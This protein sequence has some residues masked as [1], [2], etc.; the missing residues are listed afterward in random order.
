MSSTLITNSNDISSLELKIVADL[1]VGK[2]YMDIT[3]SV[4]IGSGEDLVLGANF[5]IVNPK[6]VIVKPFGSNYEIAPGLSGGMETVVSY[7]VPTIAGNYQY[8]SYTISVELY[9]A[10]GNKY[11]NTKP[12]TICEPD[13]LNKTKKYGTLSANLKGVCKDG[14]LWVIVDGVPNYK[15]A[16]VDSQVNLFTLYY[17]TVSGIDPLED[18]S[19]SNFTVQLYEGE[20]ILEGTVCALYNL[21][22]NV[23]VKINYVVNKKHIVKCSIDFCC[24]QQQFAALKERMNTDCTD[25]EK[26]DLA[27]T[28]V[29][30]LFYLETAKLAADCGQDPSEYISSLEKLLGCSCTCNCAEGTPVID[31]TPSIDVAIEGCGFTKTVVGLTHT[32]TL[33]NYTY[34]V[35]ITDNGGAL[36]INEATTDGCTKTQT[37]QFNISVVYSQIKG[38]ALSNQTEANF[39]ASV[40]RKALVGLDASCLGLTPSQYAQLTFAQLFQKVFDKF[41]ACCGCAAE[42]SNLTTTQIGNDIMFNWDETNVYSV[43]IYINNIFV[44]NILAGIGQYRYIAPKD[45]EQLNSYRLVPKCENGSS[46]TPLSGTTEFTG[47]VYIVPPSVYTPHLVGTC[48]YDLTT[49]VLPLPLGI[50]AEWHTANNTLATSLVSDPTNAIQSAYFVFAKDSNNFYSEGVQVTLV[51]DVTGSCSAPQNLSVVPAF[52]GNL[53]KFQSAAYPPPLNSY[54]VKRRLKSDT[55]I[56]AN[57]TVIGTPVWNASAS[58]WVISDPSAVSNVLYVYRAFSNCGGTAPYIDYEFAS[59]VCPSLTIVPKVSYVNYS[60]TEGG[61]EIDKYEVSIYESDGVTLVHTNT[62]IA[63]FSTPVTG[64]FAYLDSSTN[65]K[66]GVKVYI[67]TYVKDCGQE[68]SATLS[69]TS[70]LTLDYIAGTWSA[71][72]SHELPLSIVIGNNGQFVIGSQVAG[73]GDTFETD[74]LGEYEIAAGSLSMSDETDGL[75]YLSTYYHIQDGLYIAGH[76]EINSGDSIMYGETELTVIINHLECGY[77]P[78]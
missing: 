65:Y 40:V 3:P 24:V 12:V 45:Y 32:Y 5:Q 37:I 38:I 36:T 15:G 70:T 52:G 28:I 10:A 21:T 7:N 43:D 46:G 31:A 34:I 48:P 35:A 54:T 73:C 67:G 59:I 2:L 30:S 74:I 9:D 64:S 78:A 68:S 11:V 50:T 27:N 60:F 13:S 16:Q 6:G 76:G 26:A 66:V 47:K 33:Y 75:S 39:W 58:R 53:I 25:A 57:Y 55:D 8:G 20:Y 4:W 1:C 49:N 19:V 71:V 17:P 63:P 23:Y 72:L 51:C 14:K 77:Y 62:H 69:A 29:E 41:C 22:D 61:D 18:V 44:A 42:L 56:P